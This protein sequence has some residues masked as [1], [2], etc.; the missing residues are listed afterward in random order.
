MN[1]NEDCSNFLDSII[2]IEKEEFQNVALAERP[3]RLV[4]DVLRLKAKMWVE[5]KTIVRI[6]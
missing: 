1:K 4:D 5:N 6:F 3:N 2:K